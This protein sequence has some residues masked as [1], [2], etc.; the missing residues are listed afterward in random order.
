MLGLVSDHEVWYFKLFSKILKDHVEITFLI[1]KKFII[2]LL[3]VV[4]LIDTVDPR[5]RG[6]DGCFRG[7]D[8]RFRR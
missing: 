1:A 6:D 8:S 5:F 7:D 2:F 3:D 4:R